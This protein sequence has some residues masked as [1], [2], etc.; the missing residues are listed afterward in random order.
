MVLAK[1][2]NNTAGGVKER[3]KEGVRERAKGSEKEAQKQDARQEINMCLSAP[4]KT[5]VNPSKRDTS[6]K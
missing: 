6:K 5:L 1:E 2:I 3:K 4:A